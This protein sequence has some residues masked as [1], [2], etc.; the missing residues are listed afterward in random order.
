MRNNKS[1]LIPALLV[2]L[3]VL[4]LLLRWA[5]IN[6]PFFSEVDYDQAVPGLMAL[7]ILRGDPQLML[8]GQPRLGGLQAYL[9]SFIF[10]LFGPSTISLHLSLVAVSGFTLLVVYGLGKK[11]GGP[12]VGLMAAAYWALPPIFLTFTGS[13]AGGGHQEAVLLGSFLVFGITFLPVLPYRQRTL[14]AGLL[15]LLT[16]LGAW[17]SLL[18]FPFV[19]VSVIGLMGF[20]LRLIRTALPWAALSGCILGSLPFWIWNYQ[21]NFDTLIHLGERQLFSA[22]RYVSVVFTGIIPTL[23]GSFWGDQG[24]T[25]MIPDL[26]EW[27]VVLAFFVPVF[28]LALVKPIG[29]IKRIFSGAPPFKDA[30][31]YIILLF[32]AF[33]LFRMAGPAEDLGLTRY[34]LVLFVP[35]SV[36][37][38]FWLTALSRLNLTLGIFSLICLLGFNL[39]THRLY[40]DQ[41]KDQ[42]FRPVEALI[43]DLKQ[44]GI[45]YCY[46]HNRITQ[47]VTFESREKII[48]AD[49]FGTRNYDY[50]KMV[51]SAPT[52]KTA[53][54]THRKLGVPFPETLENSLRLL[55]A[56]YEKKEIGEYVYFY[57]F[58]Q[59]PGHLKSLSPGEWEVTSGR[60]GDQLSLV[61]DR[62]FLTTWRV[63][64]Q[65]GD[66]LQIDLGRERRLGGI[67]IFPGVVEIG[68]PSRFKVEC[69]GD[70]KKWMTLKEVGDYLPGLVWSKGRPLL[71]QQSIIQVVFPP[72]AGR[73]LRVIDLGGDQTNRLLRTV[74]ELFVYEVQEEPRPPSKHARYHLGTAKALLDHWMDDPTGP[75]P[76]IPRLSMKFRKK[77]VDWAG[78][79][80]EI[81]QAMREAPDWEEPYHLFG[82][83]LLLGELWIAPEGMKDRPPRSPRSLF[84]VEGLI[85]FP[86]QSWTVTT[87]HN[88]PMAVLAVD[89]NPLTRWTSGQGQEPGMFYQVDMGNLFPVR[90]FSLFL[91]NSLNDYPRVLK[92]SISSDGKSWQ[93][94]EAKPRSEYA[95]HQNRLV[96]RTLFRLPPTELRFLR[97]EQRDHDPE[98]WWSIHELEILG[99]QKQ[100]VIEGRSRL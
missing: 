51:D 60:K 20:R 82:R 14:L 1:Y 78:V 91:E 62:D 39:L 8:W 49:F 93:A 36:L 100:P 21:H 81:M 66:W 32:W 26:L 58:S 48:G 71:D 80:Q 68:V 43:K 13:Y 56:G 53:F 57:H 61:K 19:M 16:G 72:Q 23:I 98:F 38:G 22:A 30:L 64:S 17:S 6:S 41:D 97:L 87:S 2:L 96:K 50:L 59:P 77:G 34:I 18:I 65:P 67:S 86:S 47:V 88:A 83:A 11:V 29:W 35:L 7:H 33:L 70:G 95:F 75:H 5:L 46:G 52:R 89:G 28:V 9:I 10:Y 45:R 37:V 31:D 73:Y 92:V 85:P 69:S 90:G 15:G 4:H 54:L 79:I 84:P 74:A 76:M 99:E 24:V 94:L 44:N 42:P 12:R 40:L 25:A 27:G 55:S 63:L 3:E